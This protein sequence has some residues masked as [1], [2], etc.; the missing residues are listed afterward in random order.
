MGPLPPDP[1]LDAL[2]SIKRS[3][4]DRFWGGGSKSA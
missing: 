4:L 1:R 2:C 3:M